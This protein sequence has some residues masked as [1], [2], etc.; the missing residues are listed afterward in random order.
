[1]LGLIVVVDSLPL[2][3]KIELGFVLIGLRG[4]GRRAG[5]HGGGP[6]GGKTE[7]AA[8]RRLWARKSGGSLGA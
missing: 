1:M 7:E 2:V 6:G 5:A 4:S 8:E 3:F